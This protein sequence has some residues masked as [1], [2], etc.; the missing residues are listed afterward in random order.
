MGVDGEHLRGHGGVDA[1][2]DSGARAIRVNIVS[3]GMVKTPLWADM[4]E[5]DRDALYRQTEAKLPVGNVGEAV[6]IGGGLF[7]PN[8][9][10]LLHRT[11][12]GPGCGAMLI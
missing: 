12:G 8:A 1:R 5:A 9:P 7:L 3:L 6:E 4:N 11:S 10:K 2:L